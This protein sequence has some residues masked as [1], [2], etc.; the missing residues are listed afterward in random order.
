MLQNF[1]SYIFPQWCLGCKKEGKLLCENCLALFNY[2]LISMC[3]VC[4]K[5]S[6]SGRCLSCESFLDGLFYLTPYSNILT[7]KIVQTCKYRYIESLGNLMGNLLAKAWKNSLVSCQFDVIVPVPL[8]RRRYLERG[9]NQ[10]SLIAREIGEHAK[11]LIRE[12]FLKRKKSTKRQVDC[13]NEE[14]ATNV[15]NAFET[16]DEVPKSVLI[17]DDV[18]TTGN[19]TNEIARVLRSCGTRNIWC[20]AF[21][22][23]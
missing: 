5:M 22:K 1:L 20:L 21:A 13:T 9:F 23:G 18:Y 2:K 7:Q 10:S 14:R 12:N 15:Y 19:T 6:P 17:V 16:I 11:I 3:P 8:H 4:E